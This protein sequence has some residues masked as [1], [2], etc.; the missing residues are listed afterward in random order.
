[1]PFGSEQWMYASGGFYPHE[2]DQSLRFNDDDSAFLS[3]TYTTTGNRRTWTY[4]VWFKRGNLGSYDCIFSGNEMSSAANRGLNFYLDIN[5]VIYARYRNGYGNNSPFHLYTDA[6][7][8]DVSAWY[9]LVIAFDTTQAT[10]SNRIRYYLNGVELTKNG[11]YPAQNWESPVNNDNSG[12]GSGNISIGA[13]IGTAAES[14][15]DGYFAESYFVDGQQLSGDDF[16]ELKSGVWVP[17]EYEGTYGTNGF[18]FTFADSSA[19]GADSSGNGNDFGVGNLAAT[20][21]VPDSP[22]NNFCTLNTLRVGSNLAIL[23]GNLKLAATVTGAKMVSSTFGVTTGKWYWESVI[24]NPQQSLIGVE[25]G[26]GSPTEYVGQSVN[27]WSYDMYTGGLYNSGLVSYGDTFTT[28]D[29]IGI[30]VDIDSGKLWFSKN[31]TWQNSGS[32]TDGTNAAATNLAGTIFP[33]FTPYNQYGA[34]VAN[35]GQDSSFAGNK[36]AQGNTDAN[37]IGDFYYAPPAGYLALCTANL[38]DPAIDPAQDDVPEDYFNTVLY[39]G[40]SSTQSITGVGFQPDFNWIKRRNSTAEHFLHD[41][42]RGIDSVSGNY[43]YLISSLTAAEGV[44][45]DNDGVNSFDSD[46]FTLGYTNSTSWNQAGSTY[47][48]WNWKADG[49]GVTNTDGSITSTVSANQKAGFSIVSYTGNLSSAGTAT[50]GH[51]LGVEPDMIITKARSS[52]SDWVVMHRDLASWSHGLYLNLTAASG[53][54]SIYGSRSVSTSTFT[55]NY[56]TGLNINGVTQIAYCFHSVEGFSKFGSYT[57]N[58]STDGTFVYTGFRP[59]FVMVK[60][61][62]GAGSWMTIDS[63]RDIDNVATQYL[64][65][66]LSDAEGSTT[67]LDILSNGFKW[68]YTGGSGNASGGTYIFMAFAEMPF[69]YSLG[70]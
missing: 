63:T 52:T 46:G 6:V 7:M 16:G 28:N 35:F 68:R 47:V 23:D 64:H 54:S 10:A 11:S 3:K 57:G 49:A 44:Q 1:M 2:I 21:Q 22:T 50:V 51:G 67:L 41:S 4:S 66:N 19:F 34:C 12:Y 53:D 33:A 38:P 9:H 65:P 59:A 31:G 27:G 69:K 29:V 39:T 55:T 13:V 48:A 58:G 20:D 61:T 14:F 26:L 30:A 70:R 18:H 45:S 24:T 42:V 15:Y 17:K 56:V 25:N 62:N 43:Y 40:N 37:G 8:R 32:P 36:T 5:N 60:Q